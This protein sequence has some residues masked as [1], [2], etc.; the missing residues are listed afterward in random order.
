MAL[1]RLADL[2]AVR[3]PLPIYIVADVFTTFHEC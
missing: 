1:D 2:K 3:P